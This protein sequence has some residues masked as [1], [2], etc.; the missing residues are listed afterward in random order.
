VCTFHSFDATSLL[1]IQVN[2]I[3]EK[4]KLELTGKQG[5]VMKESMACAK[6]MAFNLIEEE[7][8]TEDLS[9]I[10]YSLPIS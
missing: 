7:Y 1:P 10:A 8:K 3:A 4:S 9:G 2:G 5:D 6:T